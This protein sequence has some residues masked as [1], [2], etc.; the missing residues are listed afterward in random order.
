MTEDDE[1]PSPRGGAE[2]KLIEDWRDVVWLLFVAALMAAA[3]HGFV[4][5]WLR[6]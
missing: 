1:R 4:T 2:R 3:I 5:G 6:Y